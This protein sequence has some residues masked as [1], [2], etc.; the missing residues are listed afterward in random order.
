MESYNKY[1]PVPFDTV[2]CFEVWLPVKD[3]EGIYEVSNLYRVK[4]L[5]NN[6]TRKEKILRLTRNKKGY[7][8]VQLRK[9]G[10]MKSYRVHR[11]VW[12]A[13]RYK[14]PACMEIDHQNTIRDDCRLFNLRICTSKENSNNPITKE[15]H[16]EANRRPDCRR[17]HVDAVK[18]TCSKPVLQYTIDG[19]FIKEWP[20]ASEA[21]RQL[22]YHQSNIS[23]CC[24]GEKKQAYGYIWKYKQ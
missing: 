10:K 1:L 11:L 8:N 16:A 2:N 18:K 24:R 12:E 22:G 13:F 9:Q 14:I 17:N 23:A 15:R 21:A 19:E 5:G 6:K 7:L 20:S 4:S 3:Y